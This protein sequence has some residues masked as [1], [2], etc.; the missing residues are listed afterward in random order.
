ML[1]TL[2]AVLV[3]LWVAGVLAIWWYAR[4]LGEPA[5][6]REAVRFGPDVLALVRRLVRASALTRG[7]RAMLAALALYLILPVDLVPDVIPIVGWADDLVL[8]VLALRAVTRRAG[9]QLITLHWPGSPAGLAVLLRLLRLSA[10]S[11]A[12][13]RAPRSAPRGS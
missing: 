3:A 7:L 4:R 11:D 6:L 2:L 13:G 9:G 8:V 10:P 5:T 1:L 12:A